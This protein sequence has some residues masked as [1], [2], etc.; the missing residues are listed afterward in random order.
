M[1]YRHDKLRSTHAPRRER[2]AALIVAMLVFALCTALVV[3]M[4]SEFHRFY[5]RSANILLN[6]QAQSYL[7]GAEELAAM[8]LQAD[9]DEDAQQQQVRD[10]LTELWAQDAAP[11]AL[12]DG[13]WLRGT[14]EDLEGRF[15]LNHLALSTQTQQG[16][17]A[18]KPPRFTAAQEQFIRLLQALEEPEVSQFEAIAITESISD[19]LDPDSNTSQEG[20]EDDYYSGLTPSY[21]TANQPMA[22]V[23]ELRAVANMTPQLYAAL[24][25][26]VTV[27]PEAPG[28]LNIHT[29]KPLLLRTLN[30]DKDLSPLDE[31]E[32]EVLKQERDETGFTDL[33]AFL[34]LPVFNGK[35]TQMT[36]I[37]GL[38]GESSS[39][40]LLDAEVEVA[41]R[42]LRLYSVL[43]RRD[44]RVQA[45]VRASGS[46]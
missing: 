13:G 43:E 30:T 26:Y 23:S 22:S 11:Y 6:E 29:A 21:R 37:K 44:R 7:R 36:K 8:V 39:F 32:G 42:N 40:F 4:K 34:A 10:D 35:R 20:A 25:P 28:G 33:T 41:D 9:Y 3:A 5:A 27:W 1:S 31:Q 16:T 38:L 46:L 45:V 15:N 12:D 18:V 19:W 17:R 2:G 14:L 24:L